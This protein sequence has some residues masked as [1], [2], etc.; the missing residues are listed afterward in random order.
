VET[1]I[2]EALQELE[3]PVDRVVTTKYQHTTTQI[4]TRYPP[5]LLNALDI[6]AFDIN[7]HSPVL[8][9]LERT[10]NGTDHG[11]EDPVQQRQRLV[12]F[13]HILYETANFSSC[14]R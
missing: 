3:L 4:I 7:L 11:T 5:A 8:T 9:L 10:L 2:F 13:V 12:E 6:R 14:V 1:F